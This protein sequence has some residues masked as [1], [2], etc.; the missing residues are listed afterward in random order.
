MLVF[1]IEHGIVDELK[2]SSRYALNSKMG[3]YQKVLEVL[4]EI[5]KVAKKEEEF[6]NAKATN[7][8]HRSK[9]LS[10]G[11]SNIWSSHSSVAATTEVE[12]KVE[13][14]RLNAHYLR[15]INA[16]CKPTNASEQRRQGKRPRP[17]SP[18]GAK[19]KR[20]AATGEVK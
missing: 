17:L 5:Y 1:G 4:E 10:Q 15:S 7:V 2:Q 9:L 20:R 18:T 13:R 12:I 19:R 6:N 11:L 16:D 8:R 14:T 3:D